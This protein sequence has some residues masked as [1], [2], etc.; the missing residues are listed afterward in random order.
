MLAASLLAV[1]A[2]LPL[3]VWPSDTGPAAVTVHEIEFYLVDPE[4]DYSIVAIQPLAK[5]LAR[6]EPAELQ[7]LAALAD[8]LGAD[9]VI[10]LGEMPERLIP[11]DPDAPLP[12]TGRYAVAAFVSFSEDEG[13]ETK[14]GVPSAWRRHAAPHHRHPAGGSARA[15]LHRA[16]H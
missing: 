11:E 5:P 12:T 14:P 4:D 15:V 10:L 13:S 1:A 7:R 6:A 16:G 8:K 9:A 2:S 3:G